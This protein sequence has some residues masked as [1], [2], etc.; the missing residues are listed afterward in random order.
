MQKLSYGFRPLL[1]LGSQL[2]AVK[3]GTLDTGVP[4]DC[5]SSGLLHHANDIFCGHRFDL[6]NTSRDCPGKR[7]HRLG[8]RRVFALE[9]HRPAGVPAATYFRV[10]FNAAEKRYAELA[11]SALGAAAGKNIDFVMAVRADEVTHVLD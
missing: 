2:G 6:R 10:E 11:G 5:L 1:I 7:K 4:S 8:V 9:C 3:V